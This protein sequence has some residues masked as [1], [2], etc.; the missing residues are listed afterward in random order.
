MSDEGDGQHTHHGGH[1]HT[2]AA[3]FATSTRDGVRALRIGVAGLALTTAI[4][5]AL[6]IASGSVALLGDTLHNGIDVG[7]TAIVWLAFALTRRERSDRFS[8]GYHRFEDIAG[9]A[10]VGLIAAS[11]A[12]VLYE[13]ATSFGN[14]PGIARPW[15]VFVAGFVGLAGNESVALFKVRTGKRIG[16]AALIADG[17]HSQADGLSSAGVI[18]AAI[19]LIAGLTW[20]DPLIG[21]GI[22]ALIGWTAI[23]SGRDVLL[24]L[25][26]SADPGVR[27]ELELLAA[28]VHGVG[29]IN[30]LRVRQL[31]RIVHVVANV[32]MPGGYSLALAH[33]TAEEL[34]EAWM[35]VLPPGSAV[36][37]H[38]DPYTAGE[39]TPHHVAS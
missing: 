19:G 13:A 33:D 38:V 17:R 11:A 24:R 34:R 32:C 25:L 26:D 1:S 28:E 3:T 27:D 23:E 35:H 15:L 20:L 36:D 5:V 4:Q 37:I 14:E 16:S 8:F 18:A 39:P 6:F 22:G 7:G 30:D 21:L 29:H 12:I 9:L 31:G 2:T 10:V